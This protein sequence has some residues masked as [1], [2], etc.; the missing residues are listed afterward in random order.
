MSQTDTTPMTLTHD[1]VR[2]SC[3]EVVVIVDPDTG[4][5]SAH[6]VPSCAVGEVVSCRVCGELLT[7][8][9]VLTE[10][11]GDDESPSP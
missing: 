6:D 2:W 10:C 11:E 5:C 4:V 7:D 3:A 9:S 8:S 1:W